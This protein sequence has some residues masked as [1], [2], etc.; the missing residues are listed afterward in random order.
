M[1]VLRSPWFAPHVALYI[2]C[3]TMLTTATIIA[4]VLLFFKAKKRREVW[5]KMVEYFLGV[6]VAVMTLG[7]LIGAIWAKDAWGLYWSWDAKE[8]WAAATW[9]L[10]L[11]ILHVRRGKRVAD[12]FAAVLLVLALCCLHMCWWGVNYRPRAQESLDVY[13]I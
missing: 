9:L 1:P 13:D 5:Q 8:T 11:F 10:Y 7:M 6:G 3:Y 2:Y 12:P 4:I